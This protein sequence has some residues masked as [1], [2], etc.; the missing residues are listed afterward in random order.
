[1]LVVNVGSGGE[2]VEEI[3]MVGLL[4]RAEEDEAWRVLARLRLDREKV[5]V[6][7]ESMPIVR[8]L[9]IGGWFR[10]GEIG[11]SSR[12]V[13]GGIFCSSEI[14]VIDPSRVANIPLSSPSDL[15]TLEC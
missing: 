4:V 7:L 12:S 14:N 5:E 11:P 3:E 10:E 6:K 2:D 9:A 13:L 15:A 8:D 1:M